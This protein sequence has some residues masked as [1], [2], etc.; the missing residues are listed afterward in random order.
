MFETQVPTRSSAPP[1]T[2]RL[3]GLRFLRISISCV[4]CL[5]LIAYVA[6]NAFFSAVDAGS[7]RCVL[8]IGAAATE[9]PG[10]TKPGGIVGGAACG[11]AVDG[12]GG[13]GLQKTV[14][15]TGFGTV[16]N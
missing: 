12:A 7:A 5:T 14:W 15:V 3:L 11:G 16:F 13:A 9:T 4:F 2:V 1:L 10:R 8:V 6:R